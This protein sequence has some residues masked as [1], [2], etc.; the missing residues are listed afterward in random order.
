M[1]KGISPFISTALIIFILIAGIA[2][3]LSIGNDLINKVKESNIISEA[4]YNM[5]LIDEIV[6]EVASQGSGSLRKIQLKVSDGVYRVNEKTNTIEFSF[7]IKYGTMEPGTYLREN[8]LL[9]TCGANAKA[10]E[11]DVD[12]DGKD[13]LVLENEILK[14]LLQKVGDRNN[15]EP[16]NTKNNIKSIIFKETN[17]N[18]TPSDSSII[19]D[20]I[21]ESAYGNGYSELVREGD[22]LAKAEALV[23][24]NSTFVE[25][26]VLY[27]LQSG[28]DYLIVK[29]LNAYYK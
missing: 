3:V 19:L 25:Y 17:A 23:H 24:V 5:K 11:A 4:T 29:V 27:T 20:D 14:I 22:H 16:I 13:E 2:L 21:P 7:P 12:K 9:L 6:R 10:Y 26:D 28:A 15:F 8:N 1:L 18:I